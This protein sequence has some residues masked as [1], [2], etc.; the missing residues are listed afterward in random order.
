M[1]GLYQNVKQKKQIPCHSSDT[2]VRIC[3]WHLKQ[4]WLLLC[5]KMEF[6]RAWGLW[7]AKCLFLTGDWLHRY[8]HFMLIHQAAHKIL[9]TITI[10]LE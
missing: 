10:M 1:L 7:G 2:K 4:Q 6:G 5:R 8:V 3:Q 9:F